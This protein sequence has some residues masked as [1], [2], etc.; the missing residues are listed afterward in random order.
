M[1]RVALYETVS[2]SVAL[3]QPPALS[4]TTRFSSRSAAAVCL[5]DTF[6]REHLLIHKAGAALALLR[7]L[8]LSDA[9]SFRMASDLAT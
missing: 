8:L 6:R 1:L 7:L 5:E 9:P 2:P 4:G 3:R